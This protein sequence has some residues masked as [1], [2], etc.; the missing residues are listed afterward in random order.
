MVWK[1]WEPLVWCGCEIL[2][3]R[4]LHIEIKCTVCYYCV[5][6]LVGV[7]DPSNKRFA[8]ARFGL[9]CFPSESEWILLLLFTLS[10]FPLTSSD[11]ARPQLQ[12]G[13]FYF[14]RF[15][16]L[17]GGSNSNW[18][19]TSGQARDGQVRARATDGERK[20]GRTR[21]NRRIK[22]SGFASM[23]RSSF[24]TSPVYMPPCSLCFL[25]CPW[26]DILTDQW[27]RPMP[28]CQVWVHF[29]VPGREPCSFLSSGG[30][31]KSQLHLTTG[32]R[33]HIFSTDLHLTLYVFPP[34]TTKG[35]TLKQLT[36]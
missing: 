28:D 29:R 13:Y 20:S 17:W 8:F 27:L 10:S 21:N 1:V 26:V 18:T 23:T 16:L 25:A 6:L 35:T 31:M 33:G 9:W 3:H 19:S 24:L 2:G 12:L 22:D 11:R 34:K 32:M 4:L 5:L 36:F 7:L 30:Q 15:L 14:C